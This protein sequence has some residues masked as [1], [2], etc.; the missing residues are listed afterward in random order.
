MLLIPEWCPEAYDCLEEPI[1]SAQFC[2]DAQ[3]EN[4]VLIAH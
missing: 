4:S 3:G 2:G 1:D